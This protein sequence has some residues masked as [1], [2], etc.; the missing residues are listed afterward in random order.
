MP[1]NQA[2]IMSAEIEHAKIMASVV[3]LNMGT[4]LLRAGKFDGQR[5]PAPG[6]EE[7]PDAGTS[8]NRELA[9]G[10]RCNRRVCVAACPPGDEISSPCGNA[11]RSS[12]AQRKFRGKSG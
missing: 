6:E 11:F 4:S 10:T 1:S 3:G 8:L 9:N 5:C 7:E 12:P 2:R